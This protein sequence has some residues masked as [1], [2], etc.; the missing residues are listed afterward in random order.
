MNALKR[1][2]DEAPIAQPAPGPE[3]ALLTEIR[4]LLKQQNK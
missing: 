4:D 3:Q 2:E 1:K